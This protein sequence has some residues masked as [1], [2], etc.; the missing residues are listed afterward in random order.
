MSSGNKDSWPP[1]GGASAPGGPHNNDHGQPSQQ[2]PLGGFA[3]NNQGQQGP[4][5]QPG[6][7]VLPPPSGPFYPQSGSHNLPTLSGL[8]QPSPVQASQGPPP[9]PSQQQQSLGPQPHHPTQQGPGYSLPGIGQAVQHAPPSQSSLDREHEMRERE[10]R[11]RD[12]REAREREMRDREMRE[13]EMEREMNERMARERQRQQEEAAHREREQRERDLRERQ[14]RE[15]HHPQPHQTHTGS[16]PIHQPV[17]SKVIGAIHGPNG[18]LSSMGGNAGPTHPQGAMGGNGGPGPIFGPPHPNENPSRPLMQ[19]PGQMT[20]QQQMMGMSGPGVHQMQGGPVAGLPQGQQPILNDALSYLDQVKVQFVDQ[21][22]VYNRFLDIMKDFKSQAIDT[23]GVI[24]RVSTLFAGHPNLIQGFNTF[25]P[26]GYRIECGTGDDPN[27]IRVTTPMGTTVSSMT[28]GLR[29][30]VEPPS[31]PSI[32]NGSGPAGRQG[33]YEQQS[34]VQG[35]GWQ[36]QPPPPPPQPPQQRP[37]NGPEGMYSPGGRPVGGP[38]LGAQTGPVQNQN[39]QLEGQAYREQQAA[40][41]AAHTASIAQQEQRTISQLQ[42]AISASNS[43]PQGRPPVM[44][45]SPPDGP[46]TPL[47]HG[48]GMNGTGPGSQA[49]QVGMEKRG[50]VEF[51]HA[52]SYVNKIKN[53]FASQPDIYKQ[54]L[55]ILQTY[56][57]EQKPIQDVYSQVTHLFNSAP[58][59]LEDFKQFLPESAAQA[60]AQAAAKKAAEDAVMLSNVRN[61]PGYMGGAQSNQAQ[62]TPHRTE[63][64]MPPVGNFAPPPSVGKENKKRQRGGAGQVI[65]SAAAQA[66]AA[67]AA[68][69]PTA[70]TDT[71]NSAAQGAKTGIAQVGNANKRSKLHHNKPVQPEAPTV[72]PTLTPALPEPIPPTSFSGGQT[73]EIAFF[74]RV[75]KFIG[76]KQTFNEF[77]K[78][79]NLFSQDLI[80]RNLLVHK[81]SS[82]IG[83]NPELMNWF[84]RFIRYDGKDEIIENKP[85]QTS[86]RVSLSNCRGL[87]P[88]YR[89]LPKRERLRPCSGRDEMCWEVLN[90]EWASHPTWASEDSGFVAHR[91]NQYEEGLHRIEEERHDYDFNIEACLRTIQLLE[92]IAQQIGLM[93]DEERAS[94]TLPPGIGGQ[95]ETIYKRIIKKLY[96]R[97]QGQQV[98]DD[99]FVRP[100]SVVPI[101]L[102]RLKQK[103]EEWKAAQREWEKVWREQ[104]QK[105]YWR[106]LD[107]QGLHAKQAD[108]KKFQTKTL[109]DEIHTK[110]EEQKRQRL[111]PYANVPRYQLA[112]TFA[113][114]D[115][116]LDATHLL[117]SYIE[118]A[119][120]GNVADHVRAKTLIDQFIPAFFSIDPERYEQHMKD[121][122]YGSSPPN[123]G[124]DEET[125]G[126]EEATSTRG[127]RAVNGTKT[128]LL[129]GVLERGRNGRPSRKEKEGSA[130]SGSKESTPD[131][132]STADDEV[133]GT[134][135]DRAGSPS[136]ADAPVDKWL[137]HPTSGN[138]QGKR[139]FPHNEPYHRDTFNLY[140]NLNIYCFFRLFQILYERLLLVKEYE[141]RA[142]EGVRRAKA[143]KAALDLKFIDKRPEDMFA[144]T[145]KGVNYYEQ[146]RKMCEEVIRSEL[147]MSHLEEV[148]RRYYNQV[149]WKLYTIEKLLNNLTRFALSILSNDAKDRS[150]DIMNLFLKDREKVK[151]THQNEL[152][153]RK[154]VE[155][156]NKEGDIYRISYTPPT[157]QATVMIFQKDDTTFDADE[158]TEKLR[159]SYYITSFQMIDPTEG[160]PLNRLRMPILKRNLPSKDESDE[161]AAKRLLPSKHVEDLIVR[162][163]MKTYKMLYE[164]HSEE[165]WYHTRKASSSVDSSTALAERIKEKRS[166]RF[167]DKFVMNNAWMKGLSKDEVDQKN[168]EFRKWVKDG[169]PG[170]SSDGKGQAGDDDEMMTDL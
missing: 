21:P 38:A 89:L 18:L 98:I 99:M 6:G 33:Y 3:P 53:R 59:L 119:H 30:P 62:Q 15:Q 166:S 111:V 131:V 74:D 20:Q 162:I 97:D 132:G 68:V 87:G 50:P 95:S 24:E 61:E 2:R 25:L 28:T 16:I 79:C 123:E 49:G 167:E 115:V 92:P 42:N 56:Q 128:N 157:S 75:K 86:D 96:S 7:P 161:E 108:K 60:K 118:H 23:P 12:M 153:Y 71:T 1:G 11:D 134:P 36:Q 26:P 117:L 143:P 19:Q 69:A 57:R 77:L 130:L 133:T 138:M 85:R 76:N 120:P 43:G 150:N 70:I 160:V 135:K 5:G 106:S 164:P 127:R 47:N 102:Y 40:A 72:S 154:Q 107:H 17:A 104:T 110:L 10:L 4:S 145:S 94:F 101:V 32:T 142:S 63:A 46:S 114:T 121:V 44:Q 148:L 29:P 152:N 136:P 78:L 140:C 91:K 141:F 170:E 58:D 14:Q 27:A 105:I 35:G 73:E 116:V 9:P 163:C 112:Y 158:M 151:T 41:H 80:N 54:F 125:P 81:V 37:A 124:V 66:A 31:G 90:D 109:R 149:G 93:S 155:K 100:C 147:D 169:P 64:R 65:T 34:R 84:K 159:W 13:R 144:D 39:S 137:E 45:A 88:S 8:T 129:R 168:D 165:W 55:E 22:D 67:T 139:D 113:D 122:Y 146:I 48:A 82:F 83:G 103:A 156:L 52:I 126:S 51:N